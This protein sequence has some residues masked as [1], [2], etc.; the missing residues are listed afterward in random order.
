MSGTVLIVDDD[1]ATVEMLREA[2]EG[3]GYRALHALDDAGVGVTLAARPDVVLLDVDMPGPGV[4]RL[5]RADPATAHI[6]IVAMSAGVM[7]P[8]G[9]APRPHRWRRKP[10]A[11]RHGSS[12]AR[13]APSS[14][15][16]TRG[17]TRPGLQEI[18]PPPGRRR[19]RPYPSTRTACGRYRQQKAGAGVVGC[20]LVDLFS[21]QVAPA[22]RRLSARGKAAL[23]QPISAYT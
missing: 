4:A 10:R 7:P 8:I 5:L 14:G 21:R 12:P 6:P 13:P 23:R 22:G 11:M 1:P 17:T 15:A 2:L 16:A 19:C 9:R 18:T 3:A 20:A